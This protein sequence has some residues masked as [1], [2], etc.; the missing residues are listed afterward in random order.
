M[1]L[2]PSSFFFLSSFLTAALLK[3]KLELGTQWTVN[4]FEKLITKHG[5]SIFIIFQKIKTS[6]KLKGPDM[7][8]NLEFMLHL[9]MLDTKM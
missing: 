2:F 9:L 7:E 4:N 5:R 3:H 1:F 6:F 8:Q